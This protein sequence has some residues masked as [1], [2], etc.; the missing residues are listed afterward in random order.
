[1]DDYY[2]NHYKTAEHPWL[3]FCIG[4]ALYDNNLEQVFYIDEAN[5]VSGL[6]DICSFLLKHDILKPIERLGITACRYEQLRTITT[7]IVS[8]FPVQLYE[9]Y[10]I[11]SD[12]ARYIAT[13][14]MK[15]FYN[16]HQNFTSMYMFIAAAHYMVQQK[17][18]INH[19][20]YLFNK[21]LYTSVYVDYPKDALPLVRLLATNT[22][23]IKVK[24]LLPY[25]EYI[26]RYANPVNEDAIIRTIIEAQPVKEQWQLPTVEQ[27]YTI[28]QEFY[29]RSH[30]SIT[31][32][33][34]DELHS[35]VDTIMQ[36]PPSI[37]NSFLL[38]LFR[39]Q[40][41]STTN[42]KTFYQDILAILKT[43]ERMEVKGVTI[44]TIKKRGRCTF[45]NNSD[46][47]E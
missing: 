23:I 47:D 29:S 15:D 41:S 6:P 19:I 30:S 18:N 21:Y 5:G 44:T 34:M 39:S 12:Y 1:M 9:G 40:E 36:W 4:R 10:I 43:D 45:N 27:Y 24:K 38:M 22:T 11:L 8:Q 37:L 33:H 35:M 20:R 17:Y 25:Q 2:R 28:C 26:T 7:T 16:D 14:N 31:Y 13:E 42:I 46:E 32:P 3:I